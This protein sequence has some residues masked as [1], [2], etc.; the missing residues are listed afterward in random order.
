MN[1]N[2]IPQELLKQIRKQFDES[3]KV[4]MLR[5][6]QGVA[7]RNGRYEE[8]LRLG[9]M[10]DE[11]YSNVLYEYMKEA[12]S[13]VEKIEIGKIDIPE[14]SKDKIVSLVIVLFMCTDIIET[15]VMD[16]DDILRGC[17]KDLHFELFNDIRQISVMAKEKLKY[18]RENSGYMKDLVWADK[19]DDMYEMCRNK[20]RSIV[21]KRK[22][23]PLW[24]KNKEIKN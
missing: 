9:R 10:L 17:D 1:I 8:S 20:A 4:Q 13:Q 16:I 2:D 18:L 24:G 21:R 12:E 6:Q 14:A 7:I 15:A 11:V 3:P 19:C 5:V 23:D 22:N